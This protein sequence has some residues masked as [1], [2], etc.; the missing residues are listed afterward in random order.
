LGPVEYGVGWRK[1]RF[2]LELLAVQALLLQNAGLLAFGANVLNMAIVGELVGWVPLTTL[3]CPALCSAP[4]CVSMIMCISPYFQE[5]RLDERHVLYP[6][7]RT[8]AT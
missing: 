8:P 2:W 7:W 1:V 5:D 4:S 3:H 6:V